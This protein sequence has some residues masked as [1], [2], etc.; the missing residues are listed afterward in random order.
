MKAKSFAANTYL[1]ICSRFDDAWWLIFTTTIWLSQNCTKIICF[2]GMSLL[3]TNLAPICIT[4]SPFIMGFY[5]I[6]SILTNYS[7]PSAFVTASN[8]PRPQTAIVGTFS[9]LGQNNYNNYD[10]KNRRKW[11]VGGLCR[12]R[13]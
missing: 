8:I 2:E 10:F 5:K 1:S 13:I 7:R 6:V 4:I 11:S 3:I 9:F 12:V